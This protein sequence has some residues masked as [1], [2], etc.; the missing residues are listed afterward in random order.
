MIEI[1]EAAV[2]AKQLNQ[3]ITG[4]HIQNVVAAHSP[5]KFAWYAGDPA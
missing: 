2:L 3:T 4:K 5:H 1:P